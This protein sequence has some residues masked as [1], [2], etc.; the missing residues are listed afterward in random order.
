MKQSVKT[1]SLTIDTVV[2]GRARNNLRK[3]CVTHLHAWLIGNDFVFFSID[4][5]SWLPTTCTTTC[6]SWPYN[7]CSSSSF[8]T[9]CSF[10]SPGV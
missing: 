3:I 10:S 5:W 1:L 8:L 6:G 4:F 2:V 7:I 9:N